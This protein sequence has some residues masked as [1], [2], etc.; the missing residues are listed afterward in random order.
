MNRILCALCVLVVSS[1][2]LAQTAEEKARFLYLEAENAKGEEDYNRCVVLLEQVEGLLGRPTLRVQGLLVECKYQEGDWQGTVE[3]AKQYF[4]MNPD[5]ELEEYKN[6]GLWLIRA[7]ENLAQQREAEAAA[8]ARLDEERRLQAEQQ[9]EDERRAEEQRLEE[10]RLDRVRAEQA[11][12][13]EQSRRVREREAEERARKRA[14]YE[15]EEHV[16]ELEEEAQGLQYSANFARGDANLEFALGA[17]E[18]ALAVGGGLT[19]VGSLVFVFLSATG[20]LF[21][22]LA[23]IANNAGPAGLVFVA[24]P[25]LGTLFGGLLGGLFAFFAFDDVT[26]GFDQLRA[27]VEYEG[28]VEEKKREVEQAQT[29]LGFKRSEAGYE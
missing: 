17:A 7:E 11:R 14:V 4:A 22:P 21:E 3:E 16:R 9:A 18:A 19:M 29:S 13:A 2:V 25:V 12:M 10:E 15:A 27:A 5:K 20:N 8:Q 28:R 6:I 24:G 26:D 1:P 23:S